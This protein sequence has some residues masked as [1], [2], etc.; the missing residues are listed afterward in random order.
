MEKQKL[1]QGI[2]GVI[3]KH[4]PVNSQGKT[5]LVNM[6]NDAIG[7]KV[8][9]DS[10]IKVAQVVK[11]HVHLNSSATSEL[12]NDIRTLF[13]DVKVKNETPAP[14]K[15]EPKNKKKEEPKKE[16]PKKDDSD[17]PEGK[18]KRKLFSKK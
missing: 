10:F 12:I 13:N 18:K 11:K 16:E 5:E 1:I 14:K 15:E 9:K 17:K 6:I 8:S 7:D 4:A 2:S 3:S